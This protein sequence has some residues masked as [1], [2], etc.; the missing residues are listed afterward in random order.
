[1]AE[2]AKQAGIKAI[3]GLDMGDVSPDFRSLNGEYKRTFDSEIAGLRLSVGPESAGDRPGPLCYRNQGLLTVTDINLLLGKLQ[4]DFFPAI[5]GADQ[6]QPLD[7][8]AV[9]AVFAQLA[10][11]LHQLQPSNRY[12]N[13]PI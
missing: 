2:T 6:Q 5:F 4:S 13:H 3:I 7:K 8:A 12:K 11:K 1:M 10:T 9:T